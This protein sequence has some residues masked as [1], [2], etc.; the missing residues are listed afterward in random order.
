MN[1]ILRKMATAGRLMRQYGPVFTLRYAWHRLSGNP[2]DFPVEVVARL[3]GRPIGEVFEHHYR[4]RVWMNGSNEESV[5]GPGSMLSYTAPF[6]AELARLVT[7]RGFASLFDAPCGDFN[8]MRLWLDEMARSGAP[9]DYTGGDI[10]APMVEENRRRF[11]REGVAFRVFDIVADPF[12]QADLW[13]CRDCL[14]H[15]SHANIF[16]ALRNFVNSDID[17]C[18]LTT[19]RREDTNRDIA[20]GGYRRLN[21]C[22]APF[23]LPEPRALLRD[24]PEGGEERHVGLWHR[25]D[26]AAAAARW[27]APSGAAA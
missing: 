3:R 21:L 6:R 1:P 15:L 9:I 7:E 27:P 14:I 16:A 20:N 22:R 5:S 12:P 25:D 13:L 18:L 23:N 24:Y 2:A 17:F 8:W 26:I 19:H 10:V 4:N 11:G